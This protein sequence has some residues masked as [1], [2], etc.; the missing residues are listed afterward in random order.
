VT[1][2]G[3]NEY[4]TYTYGANRLVSVRGRKV[5]SFGYDNNGN[6]TSENARSYVYSQNNRLIR[7]VENDLTLGE[8]AYNGVG[9]RI[10]KVAAGATTIYHYDRFGNLIAESDDEGTFRVDY[11]YFSGQPLARIDISIT[12]S[13]YYY[14]NDHL[15]T[16]QV[17]TNDQGQIVW[18]A[19]Y[20]PFGEVDI[21]IEK[22]KNNFR[23]P[24]QYYDEETGVHYNWFRDYNPTIGRYIEPDPIGLMRQRNVLT[25]LNF[26]AYGLNNPL[27]VKDINGAKEKRP[28]P[29][30]GAV[31]PKIPRKLI[32]EI[33]K[34]MLAY[35]HELTYAN[36]GGVL[37]AMES[38]ERR[39]K[40]RQEAY[41]ICMK[42]FDKWNWEDAPWGK[43]RGHNFMKCSEICVKI[44]E[45]DEFT[46][47]CLCSKHG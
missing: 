12:E 47:K 22:V 45:S 27:N 6:V 40:P 14:H 44:T 39:I 28:R 43:P 4:Y 7:V 23:F 29:I 32:T 30:L 16:P 11:L 18:K 26:Y 17:L 35:L 31:K 1:R 15:G 33:P 9:Q 19:D 41:Y 25:A 21:M 42:I 34:W 10:K 36:V 46:E 2:N 13:I 24:G 38:C 37:C 8:Y 3:V 20:K 5:K